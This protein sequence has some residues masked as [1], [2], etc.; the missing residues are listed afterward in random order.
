ML[1][2]IFSS[3]LFLLPRLDDAHALEHVERHVT[4]RP[5]RAHRAASTGP[6]AGHRLEVSARR[7]ARRAGTARPDLQLDDRSAHQMTSANSR[8]VGPER[9]QRQQEA[10]DGDAGGQRRPGLHSRGR[11]GADDP[12]ADEA[13]RTGDGVEVHHKLSP[14]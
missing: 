9:H 13:D 6:Q 1:L 8:R 4:Q 7:G 10:D 11:I 12:A 3:V 2:M 14:R 5:R